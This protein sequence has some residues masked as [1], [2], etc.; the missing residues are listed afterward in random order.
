MDITKI[1]GV[2]IF[3]ETLG[4][5]IGKRLQDGRESH[6]WVCASHSQFWKDFSDN[7]YVSDSNVDGEDDDDTFDGFIDDSNP[8]DNPRN[9]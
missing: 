3:D 1:L 5:Y 6:F 4:T 7:E 8:S 2:R 9:P